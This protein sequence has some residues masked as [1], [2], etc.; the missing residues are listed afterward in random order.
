M[1][2]DTSSL[3]SESLD[4]AA[5][6]AARCRTRND[7]AI[8]HGY[9]DPADQ[10]RRKFSAKNQE[11]RGNYPRISRS[12]RPGFELCTRKFSAKGVKRLES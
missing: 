12:S 1:A 2:R 7:E 10:A 6:L 3:I 4:R 5:T 8:I 9:P 11:L